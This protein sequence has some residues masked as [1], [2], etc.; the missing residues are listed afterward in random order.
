INPLSELI[1]ARADKA[2]VTHGTT[3]L[4]LETLASKEY[5]GAMIGDRLRAMFNFIVLDGGSRRK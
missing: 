1:F 2:V 4:L 5:Y 3:N